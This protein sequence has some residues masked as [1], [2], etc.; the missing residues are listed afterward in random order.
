MDIKTEESHTKI[1]FEI[2]TRGF[3]GYRGEFVVDTRGEGI[4]CSQ[5]AGFRPYIGEIE[6]HVVG[7]MVSMATGKALTYALGGLQERGTL[8]IGPS[9][10]IYEGMVVGNVTRGNDLLVNPTKGKVLTHVRSKGADEAIILMPRVNLSLE[11]GLEIMNEDEYLEITPKIVRLRK[12]ILTDID[13]IRARRLESQ[14][15]A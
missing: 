14:Q 1:I 4:I 10:D 5:F 6:R 9:E 2:P 7:S 12:K 11:K 8:Y 15:N 13:R 3:L